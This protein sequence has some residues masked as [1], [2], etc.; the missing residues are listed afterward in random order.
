MIVMVKR[1]ARGAAKNQRK[2]EYSK[3]WYQRNEKR[4]KQ[5][6]KEWRKVNPL[7]CRY[8]NWTR[9]QRR[10]FPHLTLFPIFE[11]W[12]QLLISCDTC[13][14]CKCI[15]TKIPNYQHQR[16]IDHVMPIQHGGD[17]SIDNLQVLCQSCNASKGTY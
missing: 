17:H 11:E 5:R 2:S 15:F 6:A 8:N 16:T 4:D 10:R 7:Q 14:S 3:W 9:S 12:A 13:P 1:I